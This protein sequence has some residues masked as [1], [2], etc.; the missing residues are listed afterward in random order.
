MT[1]AAC[2]IIERPPA[3]G[4]SLWLY[5]QDNFNEIVGLPPERIFG[6]AELVM[7]P[8]DIWD[9]GRFAHTLRFY[10]PYLETHYG[11]VAESLCWVLH[12]RVDRRAVGHPGAFP[13]SREETS[14]GVVCGAM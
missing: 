14:A 13:Q 8:K 11:R 2:C 12:R 3:R 6:D 5:Y 1:G 7:V 9:P 4:G 10:G